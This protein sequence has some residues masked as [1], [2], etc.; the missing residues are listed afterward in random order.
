MEQTF[1]GL[2]VLGKTSWRINQAVFDVMLE[3]WNSGEAIANIAPERPNLEIPPEPEPSKDP[4]ERRR[5]IT[6]V[7][8]IENARSGYHSQRCFQNF[9]LE[10]ARALRN[11]VFY[12]PHNIDFRG[13]AYPVPPYL[14]HMGAD[15]CRGLLTFGKG[16]ELGDN[17]LKWLKIHLANVF[18][19]DKASLKQ[20]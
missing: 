9:Q 6:E 20:R 19:F 12:F 16:K 11:E 2:D 4:L 17:G 15:H 14:N 18:G 7:K 5:W 13:R 8:L 10:I 3:A 1:K